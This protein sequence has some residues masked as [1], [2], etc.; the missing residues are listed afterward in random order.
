MELNVLHT[1]LAVSA[2]GLGLYLFG[3][4]LILKGQ[5]KWLRWVIIWAALV[6]T[7]RAL[8]YAFLP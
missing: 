5:P 8:D 2:I 1:V 3:H 7:L 6:L 4:P